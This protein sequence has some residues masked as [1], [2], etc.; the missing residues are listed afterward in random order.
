MALVTTQAT[1]LKTYDYSETSKI[2]RLLTRDHG[3]V[4]VIAKG[5]RRPKS[6]F[7]GVLEP[8][9]DGVATYYS[10]G[11]RD[12]HTLSAFELRKERQSL[13]RQLVRFAGAGLVTE[14]VLRAAPL[15]ADDRLFVHLGR[16]LDRLV[17]DTGDLEAAILEETWSLVNCLGFAPVVDRCGLCE[18][19]PEPNDEVYFDPG[20]GTV[21]CSR[22]RPRRPMSAM[23][24]LPPR[25][26]ADLAGLV[27]R[28]REN[29][30][31]RT[32]RLQRHLLQEFMAFH[33]TDDR[34]LRSFRFLDDRLG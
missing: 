23:R 33:L 17:V 10:K 27:G 2:L 31:V 21:V 18:R 16:S 29:G 25:A 14:I 12:L 20:E 9:T 7:G 28:T 34:P 24:R 19:V 13:G 11:G 8:F 26:R 15:A 30:R 22:C 1:I 32:G 3:L 5:A 4:S 6:R